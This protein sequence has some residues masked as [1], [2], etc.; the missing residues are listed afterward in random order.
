MS[1]QDDAL[2]LLLAEPSLNDAETFV[3]VLRN[4]GH[5]VRPTQV[6]TEEELREALDQKTFDLFLCSASLADLPLSVAKRLV[7]QSGKDIPVI[8]LL[9]ADAPQARLDA[10]TAGAVDAVSR[11]DLR[12]LQLVVERE[13][14]HLRERRRLRRLE[15]SLREVEK[16]CHALLDNSRDAIAYVHEGMHIYANRAYLEKFGYASMEDMEGMP[17]LDMTAPADQARFKE[18]LRSY[19]RNPGGET[20]LEVGMITE[21]DEPLQV[22]MSFSPASIEGE[23]CTQILIRDKAAATAELALQLDVLSRQDLLTGL[24]NRQHFMEQLESAIDK[25]VDGDGSGLLYIQLDNV[26]TIRQTLGIS[27]IDTLVADVGALIRQQVGDDGLAARFSDETFTVLLPRQS[28][29]DAIALGEALLRDVEGHISDTDG[30]TVTTT[31]SI[32]ISMVGESAG[33]AQS[34]L[35]DAVKASE[36]ARSEGGNRLHLYSP[37]E[38]GDQASAANWRQRIQAALEEKR[39]FLV[40]QPVASLL[41]DPRERYE[42]RLRLKS[43]DG[44]IIQP[45]DFLPHAEQLGL[46]PMLDR[47]VLH[48]ALKALAEVRRRGQD[49]KIFVKVSGPTLEDPGFIGFVASQLKTQGIEGDRLT[50]QLQEPIA[51]TQLNQAKQFYRSLREL[52]CALC[53]DHFG[54]GLNPFQ[55]VKHLPA[56]YLKIDRA[57]TR[58]LASNEESRQ[59][60]QQIID[61]AH[62][63]QKRVIVGYMEDA[64]SLAMLWQMQGDFV[65][66]NFLSAPETT[67]SYDFAGMAM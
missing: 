36:Q 32:G 16:R 35:N 1:V 39:L 11:G 30:R 47:W 3:S 20:E 42:V 62:A 8:T 9:N 43:E 51:V 59:A 49:T 28:V 18:F 24:H 10:M 37:Q 25:A 2:R 15:V 58:D 17:L 4:A 27:A 57:L 31:C 5:A 61:N 55:L 53:L 40:Y 52:R 7:Q 48:T 56:D 21:Q 23:P 65:Q 38:A 45:Q 19:Q 26:D 60:V 46:M 22:V 12:H 44:E 50:F 63:I 29:H 64:A 6:A 67:M 66:G 14:R 34:A 54:S 13:I 41:G 33:T